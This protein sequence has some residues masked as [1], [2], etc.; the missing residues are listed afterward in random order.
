MTARRPLARMIDPDR[1]MSAL[2]RS[3]DRWMALAGVVVRAARNEENMSVF[4]LARR[5]NVSSSAINE[6]E[7]GRS[8]PRMWLL[9]RIAKALGRDPK[10][11]LP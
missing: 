3:E 11:L 1:A 6:F 7:L 2:C 9:Y 4:E 10:E 5:A 8:A